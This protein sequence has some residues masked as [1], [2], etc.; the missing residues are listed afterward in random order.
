MT[1][2]VGVIN[3]ALVLALGVHLLTSVFGT[4]FMGAAQQSAAQGFGG[5]AENYIDETASQS[6]VDLNKSDNKDNSDKK[7]QSNNQS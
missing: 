3:G 4:T 5:R 6:N 2:V 7:K 1:I